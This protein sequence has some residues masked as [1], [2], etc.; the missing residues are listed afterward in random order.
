METST[1]FIPNAATSGLI[2]TVTWYF[3]VVAMFAL[4]ASLIFSMQTRT[5]VAPEH[6]TSRV[7]TA[8]IGLVAGISYFFIQNYYRSF[9]ATI[10][11]V[12]SYA[13]SK[14]AFLTIGQLRYMDW[15]ITTP[16]LLVKMF[17]MAGVRGRRAY[18]LLAIALIGDFWMIVTGY[19]GDQQLSAAGEILVGPRL[20]WGAISTIGYLAVV[21][22]LYRAW[23]ELAS[24]SLAIEQRGFRWMAGTVV[25]LWGV[26]PIGY[27]LI[28]VTGIDG[29]ILQIAYSVADVINKAG[30]GIIVYLV[31]SHVLMHRIDTKSKE[32]AMNVG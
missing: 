25:T 1:V 17:M 14:Q 24:A 22:A 31:G 13:E 11:G 27:I 18:S 7:L 8:C 6:N 9:L 12:P 28:A 15:T 10:N 19:I 29:N 30:V 20:I 21:Y 3:M 32:Y 26:Y 5:H 23:K 16:L 2:A 4:L